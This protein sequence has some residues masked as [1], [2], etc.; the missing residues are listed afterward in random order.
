MLGPTHPGWIVLSLILLFLGLSLGNPV[1][2]TGAVFALLSVLLTTAV[3][4]PTVTSVN[5]SLP[6]TSCWVG[7]TIAVQRRVTVSGGVGSVIVHDALPPE[8]QV[9]GRQQ[10]SIGLDVAG[11][12]N[13]GRLIRDPVPQAG[14]VRPGGDRLGVTGAFRHH[15][16]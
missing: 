8:A 9:V 15:P 11:A 2:L 16:G 13:G 5:R 7:D 1:L 10:P 6:R 4:P 12:S 14:V 3:S